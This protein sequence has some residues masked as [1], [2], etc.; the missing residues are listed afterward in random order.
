VVLNLTASMTCTA[1]YLRP[2]L[3]VGKRAS[4][5]HAARSCSGAP[6]AISWVGRPTWEG[7]DGSHPSFLGSPSSPCGHVPT[8]P[9]YSAP[10]HID[11]C[12]VRCFSN[13]NT[14][15][16]IRRNI[17]ASGG[18]RRLQL[19]VLVYRFR[20]PPHGRPLRSQDLFRAGT[21]RIAIS[22]DYLISGWF[23][24]HS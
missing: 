9:R 11:R 2:I 20:R 17:D 5:S 22:L 12:T 23:V 3:S 14:K 8:S 15:P 10:L 1:I 18:R 24:R 7:V 4:Q 19:L 6:N 16:N 13:F 21:T